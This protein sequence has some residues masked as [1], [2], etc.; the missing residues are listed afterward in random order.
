MMSSSGAHTV[1]LCFLANFGPL[2]DT[3][4]RGAAPFLCCLSLGVCGGC[5][6]VWSVLA[7]FAVR[8]I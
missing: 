2:L 3:A 5:G 4:E 7:A 6:G 8:I 1:W